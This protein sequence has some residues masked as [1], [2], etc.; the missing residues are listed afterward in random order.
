MPCIFDRN[1]LRIARERSIR[2]DSFLRSFAA[3]SIFS[4]LNLLQITSGCAL[5]VGAGSGYLTK[6][7][8]H[9]DLTVTDSSA[10]LLDLN[11]C[12]SQIIC[13]DED[14]NLQEEQND[15]VLSCLNLHWINEVVPFLCKIYCNLKPKGVF[16]ANFIGGS[17]LLHL[18]KKL[19]EMEI[20]LN[21]PARA[22]VSPYIT[23]DCAAGLLQKVG[24]KSVVAESDL[25]EVEYSSSLALMKDLQNMGE[26]NKM[27]KSA[28]QSLTK[29]LYL[30]LLECRE[31]FVA[32]FE[33]ITIYGKK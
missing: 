31:K 5:E 2:G 6:H 26:S 7:I 21:L 15:I 30:S 28:S 16:I 11:P 10:K 18:R 12:P 27:F 4:K 32:E 17:S 3:D 14:L 19:T 13:D 8:L 9:F 22:H 25:L 29:S 20:A 23:K 33:V 1:A 24:F